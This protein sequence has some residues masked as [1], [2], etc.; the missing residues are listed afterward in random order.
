VNKR[1]GAEFDSAVVEFV[2]RRSKGKDEITGEP[3]QADAEVDHILPIIWAL[4]N[5]PDIPKEVLKSADN[6]RV[7]NQKTHKERHRNFDESEAWAMVE[8]FRVL[9]KKL[10]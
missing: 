9:F 10:I 4:N 1:H 8:Y 7:V 5:A 3:L 6:A 2:F